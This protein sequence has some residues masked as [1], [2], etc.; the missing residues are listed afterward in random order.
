MFWASIGWQ[1]RSLSNQL[2]HK[3]FSS[4][5]QLDLNFLS[6][7]LPMGAGNEWRHSDAPN[8]PSEDEVVQGGRLIAA[9]HCS[10]VWGCRGEY[11]RF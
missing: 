7:S 9:S 2:A 6:A 10:A 11:S 8:D 1:G 4:N 5:N 3:K